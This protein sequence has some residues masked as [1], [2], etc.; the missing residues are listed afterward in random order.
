MIFEVHGCAG[1]VVAPGTIGGGP[2]DN[3]VSSGHVSRLSGTLN[4]TIFVK[5]GK[6]S[7]CTAHGQALHAARGKEGQVQSKSH[8]QNFKI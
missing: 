1:D 7:Q 5:S 2:L 8:Y 4:P 3:H 6:K